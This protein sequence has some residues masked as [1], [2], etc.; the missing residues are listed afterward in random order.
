MRK[1][2]QLNHI[3][4]P[5]EAFKFEYG[6]TKYRTYIKKKIRYNSGILWGSYLPRP[7]LYDCPAVVCR[8]PESDS[9]LT[10]RIYWQRKH[11]KFSLFLTL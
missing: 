10:D 1:D 6:I 2:V 4:N 7:S 11:H 8:A 3:K 9:S 5:S